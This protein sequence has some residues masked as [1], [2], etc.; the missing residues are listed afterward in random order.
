MLEEERGIF[1]PVVSLHL[2]DAHLAPCSRALKQSCY[3]WN[4]PSLPH[5]TFTCKLLLG[6]H[7][8]LPSCITMV[9]IWVQEE[10]RGFFGEANI[11]TSCIWREDYWIFFTSLSST[12]P[13]NINL[14]ASGNRTSH[15]TWV[16]SWS[17]SWPCGFA[18]VVLFFFFFWFLYIML[19]A[20]M[21][22]CHKIVQILPPKGF[23]ASRKCSLTLQLYSWVVPVWAMYWH[24]GSTFPTL[25]LALATGKLNLQ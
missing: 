5:R 16:W 4:P 10:L 12:G 1:H 24:L 19:L 14:M 23:E 7:V 15:R 9:I 8:L 2:R 3:D 18:G 17:F 21:R 13:A 11:V 6:F 22:T 25:G 20:C